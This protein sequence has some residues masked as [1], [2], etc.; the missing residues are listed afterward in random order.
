MKKIV[1]IFLT[2]GLVLGSAAFA[3]KVKVFNLKDYQLKPEKQNTLE[4]YKVGEITI[5][6]D[7]KYIENAEMYYE[8]TNLYLTMPSFE[9]L[10]FFYKKNSNPYRDDYKYPRGG[11][12]TFSD[13]FGEAIIFYYWEDKLEV[14]GKEYFIGRNSSLKFKIAKDNISL[15]NHGKLIVNVPAKH[16]D[17]IVSYE[18]KFGRYEYGNERIY[19]LMIIAEK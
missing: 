14:L 1:L 6:T 3:Q 13:D 4:T 10:T 15:Y 19:N 17:S 7:L 11:K 2:L 12:I 16:M 8:G 9:G 5:K 18:H